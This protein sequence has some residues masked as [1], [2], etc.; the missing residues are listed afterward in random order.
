MHVPSRI[1]RTREPIHL[2]YKSYTFVL[3]LNY[4]S[5]TF[6]SILYDFWGKR[7]AFSC[8]FHLRFCQKQPFFVQKLYKCITQVIQKLYKCISKVIQMYRFCITFVWQ[9]PV[10]HTPNTLHNNTLTHFIYGSIIFHK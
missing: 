10:K 7:W 2:Y 6:V 1:M 9:K 5:Y 4:K 8:P 3:H